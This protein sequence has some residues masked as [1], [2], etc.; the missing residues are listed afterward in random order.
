MRERSSRG[1]SLRGLLRDSSAVQMLV[2]IRSR[3]ELSGTTLDTLPDLTGDRRG[4]LRT[5]QIVDLGLE[6]AEA[7]LDVAALGETS[8]DEGGVDGEQDPA[9]ALE[10]DGGQEQADP[11][12]DLETRDNQHGCIVVLLDEAANGI[13]NGVR[14]ELRLAAR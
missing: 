6:Q 4:A 12:Q 8:A 3:V 5:D 2:N 10:E 1:G 13:R 9:A 7:L 14:S 11:E